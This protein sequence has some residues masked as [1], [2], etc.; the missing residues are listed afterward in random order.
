MN[1][2]NQQAFN[3]PKSRLAAVGADLRSS[4]AVTDA[5]GRV[6]FYAQT[7]GMLS[8]TRCELAPGSKLFRFGTK[9]AGVARV[10]AGGWWLEQ[11]AF[12][13]L[14]G[15]AQAWDL[16]IGVAMRMLCLVPPEWSDATLLIRVRVT[17][18]LLAWR[19]LANSVVTPATGGG[20]LVRMPHQND[21]AA[22]RVHQ[23]YI[24]GLGDRADGLP[25]LMVEQEYPLD[26]N[27]SRAGFLYV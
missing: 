19:G 9:A 14:F 21:I 23:L 24:P 20:V 27:A 25:P 11:D 7:G 6:L 5:R 15:F 8:P 16:S 17:D 22:R 12:N 26:A 4:K 1:F 10:Q 13:R 2:R 18:A 3:D